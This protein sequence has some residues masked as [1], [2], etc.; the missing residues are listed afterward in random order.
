MIE[1]HSS[2]WWA[3]FGSPG[4]RITAGGPP[5]PLLR[6][7]IRGWLGF[8]DG[9]CL[10][11]VNHGDVDRETL[12]GLLLSTLVASVLAVGEEPAATG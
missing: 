2:V 11:W 9:S 6:T 12:H 1:H 5:K 10:D 4:P 8:L 3:S 7:A